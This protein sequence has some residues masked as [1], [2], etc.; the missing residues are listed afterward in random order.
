MLFTAWLY[1]IIAV[2]NALLS[3]LPT[4]GTFPPQIATTLGS[5][6]TTFKAW[7]FILPTGAILNCLS[8]GLT[9]WAFVLVWRLVHWILRKI[10]VLNMQ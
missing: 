10:P 1:V 8:I 2:A 5:V 7:D 4:G 6:L 3:V 9:F